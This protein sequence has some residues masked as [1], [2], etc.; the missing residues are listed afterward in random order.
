MKD[1]FL[2]QLYVPRQTYFPLGVQSFS[3]LSLQS[4]NILSVLIFLIYS[5]QGFPSALEIITLL[6]PL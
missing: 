3:H 1:I 5:T 2:K 6:M 4:G